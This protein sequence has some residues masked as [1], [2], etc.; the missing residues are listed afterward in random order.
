[1]AL[2]DGEESGIEGK[3]EKKER[4]ESNGAVYAGRDGSLFG[5]VC[6]RRKVA[7]WDAGMDENM[8]MLYPGLS[9]DKDF[10]IVKKVYI[11]GYSILDCAKE[12]DCTY[13]AAKKRIARA[14]R[15][16]R[17]RI[18]KERKREED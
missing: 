5:R 16:V 4:A 1:M 11:D 17:E 9:E 7:V 13:E 14:R 2:G 6:D 10:Q 8:D 15:A 12:W 3:P 18:E